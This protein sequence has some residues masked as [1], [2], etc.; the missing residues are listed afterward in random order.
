MP[1]TK[2]LVDVPMRVQVPPKMVANDNG[3]NS[4]D[5]LIPALREICMTTGMKTATTGVLLTKAEMTATSSIISAMPARYRFL[6][7]ED[8]LL[9]TNWRAPVRN[10][11]SLSTNIKATVMV[12]LLEKPSTLSRG[13][14]TPVMTRVTMM[15]RATRSTEIHSETKR[16]M[17]PSMT[18]RVMIACHSMGANVHL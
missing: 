2:I 14:T 6:K 3:I 17:A 15:S 11:A 10:S 1:A 4:L 9:A 12:A 13:V 8:N 16:M 18:R 5:G 7:M